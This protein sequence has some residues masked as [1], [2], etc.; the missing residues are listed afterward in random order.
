MYIC[1]GFDGDDATS[2]VERFGRG[3]FLEAMPA[4]A[5]KRHAGVGAFIWS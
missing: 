5:T 3:C 2:E 4:M 1:G